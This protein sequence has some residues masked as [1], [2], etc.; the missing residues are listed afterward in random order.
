MVRVTV[1][2]V[3]YGIE[4][5]KRTIASMKI[6]NAGGDSLYG[7]YTYEVKQDEKTIG[8]GTLKC[9]QRERKVL[10]LVYDVLKTLKL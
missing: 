1:E 2:I 8:T 7:V 10:A 3:P 9:F 6:V 4:T 5:K